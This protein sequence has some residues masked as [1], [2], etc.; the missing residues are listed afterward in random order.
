MLRLSGDIAQQAL[1]QAVLETTQAAS[2]KAEEIAKALAKEDDANWR[3]ASSK[4][5]CAQF[6]G[7]TVCF[8]V[9]FAGTF[10]K[11]T[12]LTRVLLNLLA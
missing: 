2:A 12:T 11:I 10:V 3:R 5:V 8:A 4:Q 9:A 7:F 6:T 1:Q